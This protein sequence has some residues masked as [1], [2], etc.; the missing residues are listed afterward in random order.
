MCFLG[1]SH[2]QKGYH[3]YSPDIR[4]YYM[5]PNATFE[6]TPFFPS[7]MQDFNSVQHVLLVL[8]IHYC[9]Q[10][11]K[12]LLWTQVKPP[13]QLALP[14]LLHHLTLLTSMRH[15]ES[16]LVLCHM[17]NPLL[18][19]FLSANICIYSMNNE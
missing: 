14:A 5:S 13:L 2:L 3:C 11:M 9:L 4:R 18:Y 12:S 16:Y 19:F 15:I 17:E 1:Y 10:F 6:E 8:L 7:S